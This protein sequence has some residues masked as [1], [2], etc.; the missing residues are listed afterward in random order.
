GSSDKP[1]LHR[2]R[3]AAAAPVQPHD[4]RWAIAHHALG[5]CLAHPVR[6][7]CLGLGQPWWAVGEVVGVGR[8]HPG[9]LLLHQVTRCTL[10]PGTELAGHGGGRDLQPAACIDER[11]DALRV[12]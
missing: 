3:V 9:E 12:L 7:H 11:A 6:Q 1:S 8:K 4:L 5:E 10:R 2:P